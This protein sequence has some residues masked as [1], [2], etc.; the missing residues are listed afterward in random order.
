[1]RQEIYYKRRNDLEIR[2]IECIW[3]ELMHNRKH[4]LFGLFYSPPN[5]DAQYYSNI[6]NSIAL[7]SD[8]GILDIILTGDFNFFN[9]QARRKIDSLCTQFSLHQSINY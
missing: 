2:G 7:A 4:I 1:M 6:D 9:L 3:I 5:S 8:T